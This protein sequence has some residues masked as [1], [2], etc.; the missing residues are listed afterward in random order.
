MLNSKI[1]IYKG[2]LRLARVTKVEMEDGEVKR[3][4]YVH[5]II[6]KDILFYEGVRSHPVSFDYGTILPDEAEAADI[7]KQ[8]VKTRTIPD[9]KP[10]PTC[11]YVNYNEVTPYMTVTRK[12]F[13]SL[14]KEYKEE[15]KK[16]GR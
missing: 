12:Q 14:K 11:L 8:D 15:A 6:K 10:F 1:N 16:R 9:R 4:E 7:I 13:R 2:C 3:F 5:P